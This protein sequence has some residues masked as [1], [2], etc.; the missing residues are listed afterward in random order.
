MILQT[1]EDGLISYNHPVLAVMMHIDDES[2]MKQIIDEMKKDMMIQ[3]MIE[4]SAE[5]EKLTTDDSG[6]IYMHKLIYVSK[7]MRK[8]ILTMH[9][10]T[11]LHGH[12][13][14]EKTA[15]QIA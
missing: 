9:H 15:E 5:N 2:L 13:G 1:N 7:S 8:E 14:T 6:M 4:N 12:M 3:R 10:D 11:P